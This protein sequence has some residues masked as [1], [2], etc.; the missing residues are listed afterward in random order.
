MFK[1]YAEQAGRVAI[2]ITGDVFRKNIRDQV[3][4]SD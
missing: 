3:V 2:N 1:Q 4:E